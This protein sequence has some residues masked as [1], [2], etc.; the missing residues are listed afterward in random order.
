MFVALLSTQRRWLTSSS[1]RIRAR[2][3][4]ELFRGHLTFPLF[5]L[6]AGDLTLVYA[7]YVE[8]VAAVGSCPTPMNFE[9]HAMDHES[10]SCCL[11]LAMKR[12][13]NGG[14]KGNLAVRNAKSLA[15]L[16]I[17]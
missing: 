7:S 13:S 11:I 9:S 8:S 10:H 3:F 1:F 16:A 15:R 14:D 2:A 17:H 6:V 12:V 4:R 5:Q